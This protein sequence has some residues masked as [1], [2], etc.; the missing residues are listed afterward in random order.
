[1]KNLITLSNG[2]LYPNMNVKNVK[3]ILTMTLIQSAR[4]PC[5]PLRM[6]FGLHFPL[7]APTCPVSSHLSPPL[8]WGTLHASFSNRS[9]QRHLLQMSFRKHFPRHVHVRA[10]SCSHTC[11]CAAGC[12]TCWSWVCFL[13][14]HIS[15]W[16]S[17]NN[18]PI[19]SHM[20]VISVPNRLHTVCFHG[21]KVGFGVDKLLAQDLQVSNVPVI[22]TALKRNVV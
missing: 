11:M 8:V 17:R 21:E 20:Y 16:I 4:V 12:T 3:T 19:V 2:F 7:P 18:K 6:S 13:R 14:C 22:L 15:A 10:F 9:R 5:L 1:M